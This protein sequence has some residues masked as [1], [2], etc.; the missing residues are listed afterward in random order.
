MSSKAAK[1]RAVS[2][3]PGAWGFLLAHHWP[4]HL[5][6]C[7]RVWLGERPVWFCSRCSG[8]YPVLFVILVV[9][10]IWR[11]APGWWDVIWLYV[12]PLPAIVDWATQRLGKRSGTNRKRTLT[13]AL[14]GLSLGR[15][16]YLNMILPANTPVVVQLAALAVI[17]ILVEMTAR[18]ILNR[19]RFDESTR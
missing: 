4:G 14:L 16:V 17:V 13:G 10:L 19:S 2:R 12:V 1:A 9:Q 8:L 3:G 6:R 5:D 11:I 7:Y 18:F 15:T